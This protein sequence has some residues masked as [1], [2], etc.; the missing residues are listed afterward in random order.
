[1]LRT[2]P[3]VTFTYFGPS[4][5]G[6]AAVTDHSLFPSPS[7]QSVTACLTA[8]YLC[9][10]TSLEKMLEALSSSAI[11]LE[12][13]YISAADGWETPDLTHKLQLPTSLQDL[14]IRGSS[15]TVICILRAASEVPSVSVTLVPGLDS[16]SATWQHSPGVKLAKP[17]LLLQEPVALPRLSSFWVTD[18]DFW[19]HVGPDLFR[20]IHMPHLDTLIL[21]WEHS[22]DWF[23]TRYLESLNQ[24]LAQTPTIRHVYLIN[25]PKETETHLVFSPFPECIIH[26]YCHRVSPMEWMEVRHA[27]Y[28][29][30]DSDEVSDTQSLSVAS[31]G[32]LVECTCPVDAVGGECPCYE[33]RYERP[34]WI[35]SH[36]WTD[37][38]DFAA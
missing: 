32:E 17:E 6:A 27:T 18:R 22:S 37:P 7:T 15:R 14:R 23:N 26:R 33:P 29:D 2:K 30:S 11:P 12:A 3:W 25:T 9:R 24:F 34:Y 5:V 1:M 21:S 38:Y 28:E 35:R 13:L 10:V 20:S 16:N 8:L 4:Y 36:P 19:G 31:H